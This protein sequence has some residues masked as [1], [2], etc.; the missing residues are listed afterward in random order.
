MTGTLKQT[1]AL[2]AT[3][4][5]IFVIFP[6]AARAA[7]LD[8]ESAT[9]PEI[10]AALDSH[11]I[12]SKEL[13]QMDLN[14]IDAYDKQ[15]PNI[16]A[17]R[18]INPNALQIAEDLD[19]E[20]AA[21]GPKGPLFGIP[22]LLKD[23]INTADEP[24]TAGSL[25]LQGSIPPTDAFIT[26]QLRNEGAI[27]LGKANMTEFANYLTTGMPAGYSSLGGYVFNPY[28]PRPQP[29]GDGRPVLSPGGSSAGPAAA[30]AANFVTVAIGTETSGSILSPSNQNS[31]VGIKPTVGLVSRD[32]IIPIAASQDT[33][34]P[35]AHNVTDAA[36]LLG[37]VTGVDSKDP[38]TSSSEGKLYTDYTQF[39]KVDGLKGARI[40]VPHDYYWDN[41][42]PGQRTITENAIA[43][44]KSLGAEIIDAD[45]PTARELAN[46]NSSVLSYEFKRDLNAY[47]STLGPNAP[48]KTLA[49]VIAFNNAHPE[50]A[51][52]YG[53]TLALA[54]E[55]KDL[56]LDKPK[57]LA[58]RATDL[59]L[60]K[61]EGL[62]FIINKYNLD[63]V[64]FPATNGA[65][66]G[67]KAGYPSII[68]PD[69]YLSDGSPYGVT[70][71]GKAYSEPTLI[72]LA[73]SYEQAS[74]LRLPPTSTPPLSGDTV[75]VPEPTTTAAPT[76]L[77]LAAI[78]LKLLS[79]RQIRWR[80]KNYLRIEKSCS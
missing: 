34:G 40:G 79:R 12:T 29:G 31:L 23:N 1:T 61:D 65:A 55:A 22:L 78:G 48:V 53:Q 56:E 16:N 51:L 24:T 37:G 28:D 2:L 10:E 39:L 26:K 32:G 43:K 13:V 44:M 63:A 75:P 17:I 14:R 45:I 6:I 47:L 77:G 9:I 3:Q 46:V 76:V 33:A 50:A 8:L 15:G 19:R 60:A 71:L 70:F 4:A 5:V 67:A 49:D 25:A 54:S 66:I 21:T 20:R 36:I 42:T 7:K 11:S 41:L 62:D 69:G 35:I 57:Y 38:A 64:L 74:Q 27:I 80:C 52:K 58:D 73:Y 59:R 68:V 30:V 72:S 18:D